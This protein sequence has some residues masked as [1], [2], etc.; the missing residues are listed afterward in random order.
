M[1]T[2]S[3]YEWRRK[4]RHN[5]THVG[6]RYAPAR[7]KPSDRL[8]CAAETYLAAIYYYLCLKKSLNLQLVN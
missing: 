5:T 2:A 6:I 1:C 7:D 3:G 8:C 4:K